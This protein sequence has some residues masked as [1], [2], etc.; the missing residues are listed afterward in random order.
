MPNPRIYPLTF[1]PVLRDYLWGGRRLATL[2][3][4]NL[5]PGIVA[6]SW[7]ISGHPTAP[8]VADAGYWT[9]LLYTSPSPR[10]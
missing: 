8:T 5:P 1:T 4:R 2:Y 6:E 10:D 3:G 7:E 9:C